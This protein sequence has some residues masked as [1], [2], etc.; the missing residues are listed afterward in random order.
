MPNDSLDSPSV[1]T[2]SRG[3]FVPPRVCDG[4]KATVQLRELRVPLP[5]ISTLAS[6]Q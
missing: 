3:E 6:L 5:D 2:T 4:N 1:V